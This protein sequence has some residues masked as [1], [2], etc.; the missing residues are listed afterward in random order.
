VGAALAIV[1]AAHHSSQLLPPVTHWR[2]KAEERQ[3]RR[4][5]LTVSAAA[6]LLIGTAMPAHATLIGDLGTGEATITTGD[7]VFSNFTCTF[8]GT[9]SLG[10][11]DTVTVVSA[12]DQFGNFGISLQLNANATTDGS[13]TSQGDYKITYDVTSLRGAT[14]TDIHMTFNGSFVPNGSTEITETVRNAASTIVG[15]ISVT[16]PPLNLESQANVTGGPYALLHVLKDIQFGV[17]TGLAGQASISEVGQFISQIPE[18]A[19]MA[20]FG[21]GAM[22]AAMRR[23]RATR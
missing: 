22:A 8:T 11:C 3:M 4:F 5:V 15:Q 17:P 2:E 16:N 20:L 7:K 23:R 18:P 10:S 19:T 21:F 6:A 12:T 1:V 14:I 13:F 9:N